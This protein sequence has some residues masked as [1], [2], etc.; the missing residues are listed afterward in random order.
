LSGFQRVT[1]IRFEIWQTRS[2]TKVLEYIQA[3]LGFGKIIFPSHRPDMAMA[4][5]IVT[6]D[7]D[8]MRLSTIFATRMCISRVNSK[9]TSILDLDNKPALPTLDNA[10][11]SGL[12]DAEGCFW[13]KQEEKT[14]TFKFIFEL[15]QKDKSL[16]L[17]IRDL[18]SFNPNSSNIYTDGTCWKLCF[19]SSKVREELITYLTKYELQSHKKQVFLDW[20]KGLQIKASKDPE[21]TEKL[22]ELKEN[23]N[24]WRHRKRY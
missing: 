2:D 18:F 11:L 21:K 14:K 23:L 9:W 6:R 8:I 3:E 12:I 20:R 13:I 22:L 19:Y 4:I 24:S 16:L 17:A 7:E 10:Y 5:Y 15:S 1:D